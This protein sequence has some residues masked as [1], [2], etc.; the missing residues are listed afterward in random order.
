MGTPSTATADRLIALDAPPDKPRRGWPFSPW[1]LFLIP[2]A[3]VMLVPLVWM[4]I[5]SLE[6]S[7]EA[8]SFPLVVLPS[9]FHFH[10]YVTTWNSAPFGDFFLNSAIYSLATVAGNL[11]F[12][13]LAGYAFARL[14]FFGRDVLFVVLLATLMVPFQVLLIPTFLIVQKMGL[15]D[16][17]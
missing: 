14:H 1:H 15:I 6:T 2:V 4:V 11:L 9:G 5:L 3:A 8:Q 12:C 16:T 10:N 17:L 7:S 13:S